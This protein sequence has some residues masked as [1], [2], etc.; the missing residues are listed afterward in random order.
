MGLIKWCELIAQ[1]LAKGRVLAFLL[2][3]I[4]FFLLIYVA[5]LGTVELQNQVAIP[6]LLAILWSLLFFVFIRVFTHISADEPKKTSIFTRFKQKIKHIFY[7]LFSWCFL[8][9]TLSIIYL[10]YK[11]LSGWV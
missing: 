3:I 2:G 1:Q 10:T 8:L 4:S 7:T 5:I 9:L 11:M 6:C